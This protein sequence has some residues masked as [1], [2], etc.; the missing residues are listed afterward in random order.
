MFNVPIWVMLQSAGAGLFTAPAM[1]L[2]AWLSRRDQLIKWKHRSQWN[3][4]AYLMFGLVSVLCDLI[5]LILH[6]VSLS[7]RLRDIL[8]TDFII[9]VIFIVIARFRKS[10]T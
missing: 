7:M 8:L 9:L 6:P 3:V 4:P 1:L 10:Q 2:S 5:S